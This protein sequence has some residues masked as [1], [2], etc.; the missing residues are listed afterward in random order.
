MDDGKS[1]GMKKALNGFTQ[2]VFG[3]T[4]SESIKTAIC[5][6]C[7]GDAENFKDAISIKEYTISGLCQ[8]CQDSVFD[9]PEE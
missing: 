9:G 7:G 3:R 2:A 4:R 1:P 5:V 8:K 6:T